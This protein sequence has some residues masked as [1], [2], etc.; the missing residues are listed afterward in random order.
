MQYYDD[1]QNQK[2]A[3]LLF[4][5]MQGVMLLIVYGFVY[6]SF[7]AVGL[8][9][10][11]YGLTFMAYMPVVLALAV[12]PAVLYRTRKMFRRGRMLRAAAWV[13]GWASLIIV[14]LYAYLSQLAGV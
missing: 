9:S 3:R 10:V 5:L 4:S 12:Y 14:L 13:T 1:D 2:A 8:A 7:V 11:K 6:T